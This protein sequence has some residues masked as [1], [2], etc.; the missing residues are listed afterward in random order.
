MLVY[1]GVSFLGAWG[2]TT[3]LKR[4]QQTMHPKMDGLKYEGV[5]FPFGGQLGPYLR[6][7][8]LLV[9]DSFREGLS[10]KEDCGLEILGKAEPPKLNAGLRSNYQAV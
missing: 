9:S 4:P 3:S 1:Q 7:C 2:D 10:S 5:C 6:V 8:L